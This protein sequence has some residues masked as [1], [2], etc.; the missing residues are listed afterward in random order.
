MPKTTINIKEKWQRIFA[1]EISVTYFL[2]CKNKHKRITN[3]NNQEEA[4]C[5]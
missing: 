3:L 5:S 2:L 1:F 4:F